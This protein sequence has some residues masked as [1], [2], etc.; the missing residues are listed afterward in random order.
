MSLNWLFDEDVIE[1]VK[2]DNRYKYDM[3]YDEFKALYDLYFT[4]DKIIYN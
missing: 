2:A 3:P 4:K 1:L